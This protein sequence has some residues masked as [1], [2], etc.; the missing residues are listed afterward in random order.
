M[1]VS[2]RSR[3]GPNPHIHAIATDG[4]FRADGTFLPMPKYNEGAATYL[5]SL[6]KKAVSEFAL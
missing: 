2:N 1:R 4:L 6:G 3:K 5:P